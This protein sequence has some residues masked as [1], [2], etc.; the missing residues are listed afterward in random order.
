MARHWILLV[1]DCVS[2][3]AWWD[4]VIVGLAV[5]CVPFFLWLWMT[6]N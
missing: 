5:A 2:D 3:P 1:M 4:G 6:G